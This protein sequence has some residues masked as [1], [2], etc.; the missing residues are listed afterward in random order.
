MSA[1]GGPY[2]YSAYGL[3]IRSEIA[4]PLAAD[5]AESDAQVSIRT[6]PVPETLGASRTGHRSWQ[7]APGV[8]LLAMEGVARYLV[9]EG[10]EITVEPARE[11]GDAGVPFLL[12]SVLA[13]CLKQRGILTLHASAIVADGGAVLFAGHSGRGKSTLAAA[14]VERGH[15]M[16]GDDVT[17]I[18][19]DGA[20]GPLALPAY[21][22]LRLWEDA[23]AALGWSGRTRGRVREGMEKFLAPVERF[24]EQAVPVRSI[25]VLRYH[26]GE[27]V[28]I[29]PVRPGAAFEALLR[30]IYRKRYA[31]GL[32]RE[33]EQFRTVAELARRVPVTLI[34]KPSQ[35][36]RPG[37]VEAVASLVERRLRAVPG[38]TGK[39]EGAEA[40]T[41]SRQARARPA[42]APAEKAPVDG[43]GAP[44]V[45]LA[46]YPKSGNTWLRTLL[47]NYLG[48]GAEPASINALVGHPDMLLRE[49]FDERIGL[50][51]ADM[52]QEETL[53]YRALQHAQMGGELPRPTFYKV[54]DA[55]QRTPGGA[56]L[57]PPGATQC[58][59]YLLRNPLDVAVSY[60]NHWDW[61]IGR[62]VAELCRSEA[63]LSS[64]RRGVHFTLP[65]RL[66]TWSSHVESW[67]EQG[68]LAVHA[69][70]YEDLLAD[71]E[72]VFSGILR[73]I[74]PE[75]DSGRV[76]QAV[77][78]S[79]FDRLRAQEERFGF[80]EKPSTCGSFFRAG[81]AGSW[82]DA[83]SRKQV[84]ALVDAHAGVMERFGYLREAEAFLAGRP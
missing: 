9:R 19:L 23:V 84:R 69:A 68:E 7:A 82:R 30:R 72:A 47:S 65:Q 63:T 45:W 54:H 41:R 18:V 35:V 50:S 15:T 22:C 4:L 83:L 48:D 37:A 12:G 26:G 31:H 43:Q 52:T 46:S 59:V 2:R 40:E 51:S 25:F 34:S 14:L 13:A 17:G 10:R 61:P 29:E 79:R 8:F 73:F 81:R 49:V 77:E 33:A 5:A 20:N 71:P 60:A 36:L 78:H 58:A 70:R 3:S 75:P 62:A 21:P 16:L 67:L 24:G 66:L 11:G 80:E 74:G 53:H 76:A 39:R 42:A 56:L 1:S 6:G 32:G 55:C 38:T 57:F 44:I 27:D 64:H 28:E